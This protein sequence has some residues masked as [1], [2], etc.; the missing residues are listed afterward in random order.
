MRD[1]RTEDEIIANWKSDIEQPMIS[2]CCI[3]YNH[4]S[5]IEDAL[6]GFLIQKTDFSFEILIHDDASTD[7][8]A[9]IIRDYE[10]KYPRIIKPIYQT[11]NQYSKNTRQSINGKFNIPRAKGEYLMFCEGDDYW[12][13]S[14]KIQHQVETAIEKKVDFVFHSSI[15]KRQ[16][17]KIIDHHYK[18]DRYVN[19]KIHILKGPSASPLSSILV[20]KENLLKIEKVFPGFLKNKLSHACIQY[21]GFLNGKAYYINKALSTYRVSAP[22]SWTERT[23]KNKKLFFESTARHL[24]MLNFL[25]SNVL[26]N[27]KVVINFR[28][29]KILTKVLLSKRFT[30]KEKKAFLRS[31]LE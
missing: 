29:F 5:Y 2:I 22:G 26:L 8:T 21:C 20:R 10:K 23:N 4:E 14:F 1:L 25:K 18:K 17:N 11:D 13:S 31:V 30:L 16:E 12:N 6:E 9:G 15:L 27:Q 3:T 28:V 7:D 24:A 19:F